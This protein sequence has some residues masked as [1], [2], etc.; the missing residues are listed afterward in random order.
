M[1]GGP[2][3]QSIL[4]DKLEMGFGRMDFFLQKLMKILIYIFDKQRVIQNL[5]NKLSETVNFIF[6]YCSI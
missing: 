5:L 2:E 3:Q 6:K 1:L 4:K